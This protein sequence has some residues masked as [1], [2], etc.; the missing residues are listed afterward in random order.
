MSAYR[1]FIEKYGGSSRPFVQYSFPQSLPQHVMPG[2]AFVICPLTGLFTITQ[3]GALVTTIAAPLTTVIQMAPTQRIATH[4]FTHTYTMPCYNSQPHP[5]HVMAGVSV[6][7]IAITEDMQWA[8][9]HGSSIMW[10]PY[11]WLVQ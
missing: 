8:Q 2:S 5:C 7:V 4:S 9:I 10:I 11:S 1:G 6:I 3:P